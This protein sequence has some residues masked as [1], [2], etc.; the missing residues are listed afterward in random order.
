MTAAQ[1]ARQRI[2]QLKED[3]RKN[4]KLYYDD[5]AP[6]ISDYEYDMMM[7][8]LIRL[9][10]EYPEFAEVDS[11]TRRVGGSITRNFT[12][13]THRYPMLSLGNTYSQEE[14]NDFDQRV[15]K[16]LPDENIEYVCELKYDGVAIGLTYKKG[17]L[18]QAVTRGDGEKGDDVT[19]NIRT[20]RSI[21]L[22]LQGDF[23]EEFEI[24][25]EIIMPRAGFE[26]LNKDREEQGESG[27]A[28]PRN[29]AAGS[30]KMQDSSEVARRPLD[31]L[32]YFLLGEN[33]KRD[34][35]YDALTMARGWGFNIPRYMA[36]CKNTADIFSFIELWDSG[37]DELPFD[38][39]G[40]VIKVNS[41]RHQQ[42]LGFT[43][44]SPRWAIA[45]KF[46]ARQARSVLRSISYQ[47]GRTGAV[48][49]V[50]NLDPVP[51]AGTIVKRASLHNADIIAK[52]DVREGDTV[53][54]EKG[55]EIIPKIVGVVTEL[56]PADT[57][58]TRYIVNCPE[59]GT[60]LVR[61]EGEAAYY[62]PNEDECPPQI[63]G[64]IEHFISRRAMNIDSL[65]EGKIEIL[66]DNKLIH[67]IADLYDLREDQL[68]GLEKEYSSDDGKTR[69]MRFR[70]KSTANIISGIEESKK[71]P[72]ERLLFALGIRYVGE[73]V[74]RK[75]A[76]HFKNLNILMAASREELL[77]VEE[78][79][80]RIAD[81]LL[82]WFD[83][84]EHLEIIRRLRQHGLQLSI[85]DKQAERISDVLLGKSFVVSGVFP[86]PRD[87]VK[88]MIE[89][90]GGKNVGSI[91]AKTS[92]VLAG[93]KMG[94]EKHKKAEKLGIPILSFEDFNKMINSANH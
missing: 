12:Q 18:V 32:L 29:A 62:C 51:L 61:S 52:L 55:G 67:N 22:K 81:S 42:Q 72:F 57:P 94:P 35:H 45:Y 74:A 85:S 40:V 92:F 13:V 46:K 79:G 68:L 43:A 77:E 93:D 36:K 23:P 39:D 47:V 50:A 19:A 27:F 58:P 38:I 24:R 33:I 90:H 6:V 91:S 66:F 20:I 31:C 65:G 64:K 16:L 10:L 53:L 1:Q 70:E 2:E 82:L 3:I 17:I 41:F 78:I 86:I 7:Q 14:I 76:R 44:K 89:D 49:P 80:D 73:T 21:P 8:E 48:T 9:E 54:V 71:V 63:K 59:C 83:K 60:P 69:V 75:L 87:E 26:K 15:R 5:A 4:D 37:R 84:P 30:I 56:R 28:N 25:G 11:P 88:K 34:N